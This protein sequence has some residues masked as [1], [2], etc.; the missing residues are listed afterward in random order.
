MNYSYGTNAD[1]YLNKEGLEYLIEQLDLK[2]SGGGTVDLTN[3]YDKAEI[4]NLLANIETGGGSTG[5]DGVGIQS[6]ELVNY[7]LIVTLTDDT[8]INLGNVRGEKGLQG[9]QGL[10]GAKGTD[11]ING[12]NG[13]DGLDGINGRGI[14]SV[15]KTNTVDLV[16]TY[17]ITYSDMTTSNFTITNG[18]D[19]ADGEGGSGGGSSTD[20]YSTDEIAIGTWIDGKTIYRKVY[21]GN[22][23]AVTTGNNSLT[24]IIPHEVANIGQIIKIGIIVNVNA[25][26]YTGN[27]IMIN[28]CTNTTL[29]DVEKSTIWM[30]ADL[31][32]IYFVHGLNWGANRPYKIIFE[33]TKTV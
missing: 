7:E 27:G 12:T 9:I 4:D 33:Y 14:T 8:V 11:G 1:Q 32:S 18:K 2:Y 23:V 31:T 6:V 13:I 20:T 24:E 19:G 21:T 28:G 17:T 29:A 3:Y 25:L 22:M 5:N 15:V 10:D 16:D 26:V 30:I